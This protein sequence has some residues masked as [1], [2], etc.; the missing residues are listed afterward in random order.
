M[1]SQVITGRKQIISYIA[2]SLSLVIIYIFLR[3]SDWIGGK[4]IHTIMEVMAT[5]LAA[6]VGTLALVRYYTKKSNTFLFIGTGFL[7]TA[8]LDLYHAIVTSTFF[9]QFWQ[10][11]PESL[12]PW[13]WNASRYFLGVMMLISW[14]AWRREKK[15]GSELGAISAKSAYTI[16]GVFTV[17]AFLFFIFYP[18]PQAY[19]PELF[20]GR[21]EEFGAAALFLAAL[22]GY[23]RKGLWKTDKFEHW[24]VY[25]LIIGLMGQLL[26]MSSSHQL[27]DSM[28]DMAH[29]LKKASY[30][31]VLSGLLIA[32]YQLFTEADCAKEI[33]AKQNQDLSQ[34]KQ[35]AEEFSKAADEKKRSLE[36]QQHAILNVLEDIA[37][38]KKITEMH[39]QD[40]RK[41]QQAVE[42][43]SDHIIITDADGLILYANKAAELITGFTEKEVLGKKAGTKELWGG[44]MDKEVYE[45]LWKTIKTDKKPFVGEFNNKR[46]NGTEYTAKSRI[47]P[48]L[49]KNGEVQFFVGIETDITKE[50][51]VDRMKTEFIS[52]ASH[53][54]R[55]PLSATK[56]FSEMLIAGDAGPLNKEQQEFVQNISDSN[57]RMVSLVNAL[58]N[59]SRIESGRIVV[60]ST[61]T[62]LFDIVNEVIKEIESETAK[63]NI[64]IIASIT[65]NAPKI[66]IDPKLIKEVYKNVITNAIKYSPA[67]SEIIVMISKKDEEMI[68]QISDNGIGI[69]DEE[70]S[71]VFT[72]FFRANNAR[73]TETDGSGLGLYL[74]KTIIESSGGKI[75]FESKENE[76]TTFWFTLPL[77]GTKSKKG[78]VR[79]NS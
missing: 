41:F 53:Q 47:S 59:I 28:F 75:R 10:N 18:L 76:G 69:P 22:I 5:A 16:T 29:L 43:A 65:E 71:K 66:C 77:K 46:K 63:K 31:A 19:Y 9:D 67:E 27:F 35:S 55:T 30:L 12:I 14:L 51:N 58:L 73:Q 68:T 45:H 39:A 7:G 61:P 24:I 17:T 6:F 54:L 64:K 1:E 25:S 4:Q 72:K 52:L 36:E 44:Q 2:L 40:L 49:D 26:F 50:K 42:N 37:H 15:L 20:F 21:P 78:E 23:L 32:M 13:S 74:A 48:I 11:P 62:N 79:I 60:D 56:W 34:A 38:E 70:Q 57:E 33:L 8:F 3:N